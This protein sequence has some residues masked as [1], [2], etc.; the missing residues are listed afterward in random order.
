MLAVQAEI[1]R[2]PDIRQ[3]NVIEPCRG[4]YILGS[5]VLGYRVANAVVHVRGGTPPDQ[6]YR[7]KA[8]HSSL[9]QPEVLPE[10]GSLWNIV[11]PGLM[12]SNVTCCAPFQED[13]ATFSTPFI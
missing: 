4:G 10:F 3:P 11:K 5:E 2:D 13:W 8:V 9:A 7:P 12:V 6:Q 1:A